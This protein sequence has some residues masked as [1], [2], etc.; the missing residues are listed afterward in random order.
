MHRELT[1]LLWIKTLPISFEARHNH[2]IGGCEGELHLESWGIRYVSEEHGEWQWS[3]DEILEAKRK[4][5]WNFE[6]VTSEKDLP[7]PVLGKSKKYKFKLLDAPL[8]E[9]SW[10]RYQR[11]MSSGKIG[12]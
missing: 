11:L 10:N 12:R 6:I 7:V 9:Q 8:E 4:D 2:R 5:E 3:P 1:D